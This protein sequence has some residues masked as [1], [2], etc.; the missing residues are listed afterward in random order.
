M[1][2]GTFSCILPLLRPPNSHYYAMVKRVFYCRAYKNSCFWVG[3][4]GLQLWKKCVR[5]W[6]F[7]DFLIYSWFYGRM[8]RQGSTFSEVNNRI[9]LDAVDVPDCH[10][11]MQKMYEPAD[12]SSVT[13][14]RTPSCP[15]SSATTSDFIVACHKHQRSFTEFVTTGDWL[16][17][18]LTNSQMLLS[19][20]FLSDH[21]IVRERE[22]EV[23][24]SFQMIQN[25]IRWV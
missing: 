14:V 19:N 1:S 22:R 13:N 8:I 6:V 10:T 2:M 24:Y 20:P 4:I 9:S 7:H 15:R 5:Q 11:T 21:S 12:R 3:R 17:C 18:P 16:N 25:T 23:V